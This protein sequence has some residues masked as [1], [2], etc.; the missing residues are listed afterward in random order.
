MLLSFGGFVVVVVCLDIVPLCLL[1]VG[2]RHWGQVFENENQIE[3]LLLPSE[4]S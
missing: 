4:R 2:L 1:P 3:F